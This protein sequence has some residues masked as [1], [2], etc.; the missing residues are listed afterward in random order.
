VAKS[1][2]VEVLEGKSSFIEFGGNLSPLIKSHDQVLSLR[3][4]AFRENRLP[5]DVKVK[6]PQ[7]EAVGRIAFMQEAKK[8]DS[9]QN[10]ICNLSVALPDNISPD[11]ESEHFH[12]KY[13]SLKE[14]GYGNKRL[15]IPSR[16]F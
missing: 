7:S 4:F 9:P 1:R 14:S 12:D 8:Q 11:L 13:L 10:P 15:K 5:F 2:D 16:I 6:D 3:F